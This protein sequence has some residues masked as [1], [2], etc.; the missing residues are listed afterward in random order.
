MSADIRIDVKDDKVKP[1]TVKYE[2]FS[3]RGRVF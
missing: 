3:I 1:G 2:L